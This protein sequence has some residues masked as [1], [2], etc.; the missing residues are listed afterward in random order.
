MRLNLESGPDAAH[1]ARDQIRDRFRGR[2]DEEGLLDLQ[3][4]VSELVTN[5]LRYGPGEEIEVDIAMADDGSIRGEVEDRGR[6]RVAVREIADG[7][8]GF[9]LRIVDAVASS[10]GVYEGSTHV[11][12]RIDPGDDG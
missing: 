12:F 7:R 10:W 11:W 1:Q 5:S 2:V 4:I 9:G 3:L 8:G 6:G